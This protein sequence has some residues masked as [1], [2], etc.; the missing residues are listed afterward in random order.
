MRELPIPFTA[1]NAALVLAGLKVQTRRA[2]KGLLGDAFYAGPGRDGRHEFAQEQV[3]SGG[4]MQALALR[5]PHG[6]IGDRLW[7]REP[8][9]ATPGLDGSPPR[10]IPQ[11][12]RIWY[13]ADEK[14]TRGPG[15]RA[16]YR[17]AMFM[18]RWMSRILLEVTEVR[19][20][21]LNDISEADACAEGARAAD[22]VTGREVLF[23]GPSKA[24]SYV[25][26]YRDIWESINGPGSWDLNPWVWVITFRRV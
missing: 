8:W 14:P 6:Q 23:P 5:C 9:R 21:R 1:P 3:A 19:V 26:H 4:F 2:V 15:V 25:L 20:E 12:Q 10:E 16:R 24:G 18:C 13:V 17:Q 22:I 11:D 7:V